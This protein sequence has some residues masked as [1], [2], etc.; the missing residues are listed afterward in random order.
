M[1]YA[2]RKIQ[3]GQR[4]K[5][6]RKRCHLTQMQLLER[7]YLSE[8]SV[9][10]LRAWEHGERL[11]D[12]DTLCRMCDIFDCDTGYLLCDY[13]ARRRETADA[14]T[15]TGLSEGAVHKLQVY[16]RNPLPGMDVPVRILS[17][18]IESDCFEAFMMQIRFY[19]GQVDK[20][21]TQL[22]E[23]E[24]SMITPLRDKLSVSRLCVAN[25]LNDL[26]DTLVP[27]PDF[28]KEERAAR[29][30]YQERFGPKGGK[31]NGS[32]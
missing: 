32:N 31:Q 23:K 16:S 20:I 6:N 30:N 3:I 12:L 4:I 5:E 24:L 18:L 13:D 9:A 29:K 2:D 26:L 27:P 21:C 8:K 7:C 14:C 28:V 22:E 11:P 1:F 19:A 17:L 10:S 25:V 15:V